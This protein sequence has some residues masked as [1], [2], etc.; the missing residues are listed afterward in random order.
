MQIHAT[1]EAETGERLS[2]VRDH[3]ENLLQKAAPV[4]AARARLGT[5]VVNGQSVTADHS[6]DDQ[7]EPVSH[8]VAST[9]SPHP[10][11]AAAAARGPGPDHVARLPVGAE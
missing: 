3:G 11:P 2:V 9:E 8:L 1:A 10:R 5:N 6:V 4:A 7:R